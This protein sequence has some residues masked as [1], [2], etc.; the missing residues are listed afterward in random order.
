MSKE[1]TIVE[2]HSLLEHS[3]QNRIVVDVRMPFEVKSG[4]INGSCNIPLDTLLREVERLR[5]YQS[6]YL[7]CQSGGRSM[8]AAIQLEIAG[9]TNVYNVVGGMRMWKENG[10]PIVIEN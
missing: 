1:I 8:L 6:V 10:Y 2:L 7:V 4:K 9:L 3:D 5:P